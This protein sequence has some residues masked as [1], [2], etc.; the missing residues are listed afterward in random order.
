MPPIYDPGLLLRICEEVRRVKGN[1]LFTK[2]AIDLNSIFSKEEIKIVKNITKSLLAIAIKKMQI[3][4]TLKFY[5]TPMR[6]AKI[7]KTD[8]KC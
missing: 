6:M 1:D 3:K 8:K 4:T 7:N 2:W 5:L